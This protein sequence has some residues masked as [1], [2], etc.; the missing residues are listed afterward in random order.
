MLFLVELPRLDAGV[1]P[2]EPIDAAPDVEEDLGVVRRDELGPD[3]PRVRPVGLL[4]ED[5]HRVGRQDGVVVAAEHERGAAH[6][7]E[8]LVG[9]AAE[10][11][12]RFGAAMHERAGEH[13]SDPGGR[14]DD[15]PGVDDEDGDRGIV[16]MAQ[17]GERRL[18]E[19]ARVAG[20]DDRDHG[21]CGVLRLLLV[22]RAEETVG[23][24]GQAHRRG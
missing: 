22:G 16:L 20:D 21:R 17:R 15:R 19:R 23:V 5:P 10:P 7:A 6:E 3:D 2:A 1:R 13:R 11:W 18:E 12:V 8:R 24:V 4:H 14:V 9:G